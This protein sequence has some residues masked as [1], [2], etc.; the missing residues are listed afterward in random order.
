MNDRVDIGRNRADRPSVAHVYAVP[1]PRE[2]GRLAPPPGRDDVETAPVRA[3][4]ELRAE[5]PAA[6]RDEEAGYQP[7]R[8]SSS[9]G[10]SD[11][12]EMPTIASPRPAETSASTRASR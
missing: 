1:L 10:S 5:V 6:A 4:D 2:A 7:R 11:A 3:A 9:P 12:V 8:S